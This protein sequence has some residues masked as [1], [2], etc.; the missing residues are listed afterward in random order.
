MLKDWGKPIFDVVDNDTLFNV[1]VR[2]IYRQPIG[3]S[4][5][6]H[7]ANLDG[8]ALESQDDVDEGDSSSSKDEQD[9]NLQGTQEE[10]NNLREKTTESGFVDG[11]SDIQTT[12][13]K[14]L[15][16][17]L[18]KKFAWDSEFKAVDQNF[19]EEYENIMRS[20]ENPLMERF[21]AIT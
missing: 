9:E 11:R 17:K 3:L 7:K 1:G 14:L 21:I 13:A 18:G 6:D 2:P 12:K 4:L 8:L 16:H 19:S 15:K 20:C 5:F 10:S